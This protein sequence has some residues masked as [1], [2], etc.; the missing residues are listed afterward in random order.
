MHIGKR[1]IVI[2]AGMGGLSIAKALV[3]SFEEILVLEREELTSVIA[4][5]AGIPQGRHPHS[6]L[7]GG[8]RALSDLFDNFPELLR[9][10]GAKVTDYGKR[11]RF[12]FPG[13]DA[14]P[15]RE[16]GIEIHIC[17]RP[18]VEAVVRRCVRTHRDINILDRRR[19]TEL[20][21]SEDDHAVIGVRCQTRGG[22][23]ESYAADLVVDASSRGELTLEFLRG[24]GTPQPPETTI[25]VDYNY[26][27]A[28]VE[29]SGWQPEEL[30]ILTFPNAPDSTRMGVLVKR[31]DDRFFATLCG[32]G[33]D[34]PPMEWEAFVEFASTLPTD[35]L[36]RTLKKSRV[37]GKIVQFAFQ[38][39]RRRHFEEVEGWPRGLIAVADAV[40]RFNPVHAQGMT[41]A[42]MEAV[43]LRDIL[44]ARRGSANPLERL[45]DELMAKI[46]PVIDN[47][48]RLAALPDLAFPD[49]RG[50]RPH[51][52]GEALEYQSQL[53]KAALLDH[54]IHKLLLEVIGLITPAEALR[55]PDVVEKVRSLSRS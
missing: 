13:Q 53:N 50:C 30:T 48:W 21:W 4:P 19:V 34:S 51:D 52:L 33:V 36:H 11:M 41:V 3:D 47:V 6:L 40:C 46:N 45:M 38:E 49:A 35:T 23:V 17:T 1:A 28:I 37:H 44:V 7:P 25:G 24:I 15:E 5:R 42:A 31:E 20:L 27:T 14:L 16:V 18:L 12:E 54:T 43:I 32:R 26:A 9:N 39:S 8:T 10:A 55:M 2:G 22:A 29:F